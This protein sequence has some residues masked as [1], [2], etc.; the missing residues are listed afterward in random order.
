LSYKLYLGRAPPWV[1]QEPPE[2]SE[3]V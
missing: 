1:V 3:E 2:G